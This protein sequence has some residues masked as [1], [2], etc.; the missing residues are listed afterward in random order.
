M[1]AATFAAN[2]PIELRYVA[3]GGAR[4][5][6]RARRDPVARAAAFADACRINALSSIMEAGSGH[7]GTSFCVLDILAWLHL[8]VLRGRRRL[9]LLQGP[10]RARRLRRARR[11]G[12]ARLRPPA[13]AAA[14]RRAARPPGRRTPCRRCTPTPARSAWGS[15]RPRA[16]RAR[17]GSH[18]RRRRVFVDHRRR[19]AAGGPVLGVARPGGQ[20]GLRRDHGDR[21][22]QQDPVRH[23]GRR[24]S[25]DLGDLEA[26]VRAFGWA[27]ARCDGNDVARGRRDARRAAASATE[28]PKLLVA[29]TVKGARR[30][31]PSSR[32]TSSAAGT[33]LYAYH[34][35]A[36]APDAYEA[37]LAELAGRLERAARPRRSSWRPAQAPRRAAPADAA[38]ARRRLRRGAGRG[39]RRASRGSSRSTPTSTSTA[40]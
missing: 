10:R 2:A 8:E 15:R 34:S 9:L 3:A 29:D 35:G 31:A 18:G 19:R 40:G 36:P 13:P 26:K 25:A 39:R 20:R 5:H 12:Q 28:R 14:A 37:A 38:A 16:S 24:R 17:R 1:E 6:P 11:H 4:A 27:V 21:R 30:A 33:A 7:I 32:T 22:P 23:L